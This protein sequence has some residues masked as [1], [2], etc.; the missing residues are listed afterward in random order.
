MRN[1]VNTAV[2]KAK[3]MYHKGLLKENSRDLIKFWKTLKSIYFTKSS[4]K[5][6]PQSFEINGDKVREP[7]KIANAYC[8]FFANI[9]TPLKEKAFPLCNFTWRN[10][11]NFP[12]KTVKKFMFRKVSKQE[13]E[14][15]RKSIKRNKAT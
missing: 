14:L 2:R 1:K 7:S 4:D 13:V 6:S 11:P 8:S 3:S 9:L 12:T 10:Q 15:E 5:Q